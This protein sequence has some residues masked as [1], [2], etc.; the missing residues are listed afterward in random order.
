MGRSAMSTSS[1]VGLKVQRGLT[2][3]VE[4]TY[5]LLQSSFQ[6][7]VS[8]LNLDESS[9]L[10]ESFFTSGPLLAQAK[11]QLVNFSF[12]NEG[13]IDLCFRTAGQEIQSCRD[14]ASPTS[15]QLCKVLPLHVCLLLCKEAICFM[16]TRDGEIK[17]EKRGK[18]R[19][20]GGFYQNLSYL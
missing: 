15:H 12:L 14:A 5:L 10:W 11:V 8:D 17:K 4:P 20:I 1:L 2:L 18:R 7:P 13:N 9:A 19:M 16:S 3:L 6:I